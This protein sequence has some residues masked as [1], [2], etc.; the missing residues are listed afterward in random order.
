ME[1]VYYENLN[2]KRCYSSVPVIME[3]YDVIY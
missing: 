2:H 1:T 3:A